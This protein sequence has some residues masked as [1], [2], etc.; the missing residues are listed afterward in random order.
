VARG[1]EPIAHQNSIW[2][3]KEYRHKR[4]HIVFRQRQADI[5]LAHMN[6]WAKHGFVSVP[7]NLGPADSDRSED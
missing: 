1:K 5:D 2:Q 3:L 6:R 7:G 4:E